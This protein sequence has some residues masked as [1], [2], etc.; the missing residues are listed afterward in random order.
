MTCTF[1]E[2]INKKKDDPIIY[3]NDNFIVIPSLRAICP[4]HIL[5]IPK[6]HTDFLFNMQDD[7]Y[8]E[9]MKLAKK[10]GKSLQKA[11]NSKTTGIMLNG[12]E[13]LHVHLHLVPRSKFGEIDFKKTK[14]LTKKELQYTAKKIKKEIGEIN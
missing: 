2:I 5:V 11:Y 3:E 12:F 9:L 1:C 10:I 13:V 8:L 7:E 14:E 4:G 6:K